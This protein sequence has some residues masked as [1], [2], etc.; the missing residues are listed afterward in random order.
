MKL[1]LLLGA[2]L[3]A[4]AAEIRID[5]Y[6]AVTMRDGVVLR[7]DVYRPAAEGKYPTLVVR[8]PY[9]VQRDGIHENLVRFAKAGYAVVAQDVRGRYES[10]GEWD[11]F[12]NE[13]KDGYDTIEWAAKQP[14]SNGRVG[15]QGGSYLG[16]VQWAALTQQPPHLVASFPAVAS[17]NIYANWLTHGGAFRLSFNYGWGVVRMPN[18]I[19]LPQY[20]HTGPVAAEELRYEKI[21]RHL[22]L[23]TGDQESAHYAVKHY[24]DWLAHESYDAY[25][26]AISDEERFD[27]AQVPVH[28]QGGWFDIFLA[29]T[30]NGFVGARTKGGPEARRHSRMVIGPWGHGPSRKFGQLD[31]GPEADRKLFDYEMRFFDQYVKG[32]DKGLARALPVEIFYMGANKWKSHEAWPVPGAVAT[33]F[34]LNAGGKLSREKSEGTT[35]Y[36]YDPNDPVPTTGGNNCCGTPTVAGPVDQGPLDGRKDIARFVGEPLT[37]PLAIAGPVK[38]VL[39]A[40][41]DGPDTDWMVKLIDVYPDGKAYPMAEGMLR[42]RFRNGLD[43]PARLTPNQVYEFTVDMV[44]T[45]VVFQPGHRIRVDVSSSNFPQFDRNLNTGEA[46]A[47]ASTAR[48]ARQTIHH[49][50]AKASYVVLPVVA[51]P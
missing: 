23:G 26:K 2:A 51:L 50:A 22:P 15:T 35:T 37:A 28:T 29:G 18:R 19:M 7:A 10:G 33:P 13:A 1:A 39:Q 25:W 49:G 21:L 34:Y 38:M 3:L 46:L 47:T 43:K 31:F 8:T 17:T 40:A 5:R 6:Q 42:A 36:T 9:G 41:T 4:Q 24:R 48:V 30:I 20:W 12:R 45:A 32:E 11:P 16:H 14:W 44:G 27:K